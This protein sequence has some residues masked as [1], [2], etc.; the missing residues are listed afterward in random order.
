MDQEPTSQIRRIKIPLP[1]LVL[2]YQKF[3]HPVPWPEAI[4]RSLKTGKPGEFHFNQSAL[5]KNSRGEP[6][7][8]YEFPQET[9][10][11]IKEAEKAGYAFDLVPPTGGSR[12]CAGKDL[13]EHIQALDKR[14]WKK[15]DRYLH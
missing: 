2:N 9:Q 12:I 13:I 6:Q 5:I 7:V 11:L 8:V 14:K 3:R 4:R 1:Y 15:L 10:R